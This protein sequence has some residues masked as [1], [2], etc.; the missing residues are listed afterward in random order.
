MGFSGRRI[1]VLLLSTLALTAYERSEQTTLAADFV[2]EAGM[3][4]NI[5]PEGDEPLYV[6]HPASEPGTWYCLS[7]DALPRDLQRDST[8]VRFS[9][10]RGEIP[11]NVRMACT[12]LELIAIEKQP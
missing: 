3:I 11:P 6:V 2:D 1:P 8:A 7:T 10:N 5:Y 4:E 9:G 12:P